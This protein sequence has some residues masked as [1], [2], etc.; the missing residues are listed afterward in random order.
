MAKSKMI[1]LWGRNPADTNRH[2]VPFLRQAR[3]SG[4]TIVLIDPRR[5]AS[6]E[7]AD[8]HLAI[9]PATDGALALALARRLIEEARVMVVPGEAFGDEAR[10]WLRISYAAS[11][12]V[13][14]E[15]AARMARFLRG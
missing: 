13:L 9:R 2:M 8:L 7:L 3:Q 11:E 4:A 5:S 1:I 15:A 12:E 14:E 6:A 10:G